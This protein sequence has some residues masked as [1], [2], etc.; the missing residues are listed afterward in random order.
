[1]NIKQFL[2]IVTAAFIIAACQPDPRQAAQATAIVEKAQQDAANQEQQ[3]AHSEQDHSLQV[4]EKELILDKQ[5]AIQP[6][7]IAGWKMFWKYF[8]YFFTAAVCYVVFMSARTM[9]KTNQGLGEAAI[10]KA[11]SYARQIPMAD[12]GSFPALLI[13]LGRGKYSLTDPNGK[14]TIM[15]D[16]RNLPDAQMIAG[17]MVTRQTHVLASNA[18]RQSDGTLTTSIQPEVIQR[19]VIDYDEFR[20]W[21]KL[22]GIPSEAQNDE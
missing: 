8:F 10:E 4:Q 2:L 22:S 1:M 16:E 20:T 11:M 18:A 17:A 5:R 13:P 14:W 12:N 3:R 9:V 6:T 19:Q 7:A 15:L 21:M